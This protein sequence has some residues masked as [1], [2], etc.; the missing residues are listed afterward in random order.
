MSSFN[1]FDDIDPLET[2]EW[3]ESIDSV[4]SQHGPERA[5]FLLNHMIDYA[6]RSGAYLPYSPNT[7]YLNTIPVAHQ[8][9]YPG[10]RTLERRIEAEKPQWRLET[11]NEL[12]ALQSA[13][14]R[15]RDKASRQLLEKRLTTAKETLAQV[16][17]L[18][19]AESDLELLRAAVDKGLARNSGRI[20]SWFTALSVQAKALW[21][22]AAGIMPRNAAPSSVPVA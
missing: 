10:D 12:L 17:D 7:A 4:L 8:P 16:G 3:L 13:D 19:N 21:L 5:H 14:Q 20:E 1:P 15:D 22:R 2:G 6:R 9:E 11:E 18:D